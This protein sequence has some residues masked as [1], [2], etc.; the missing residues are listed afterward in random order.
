MSSSSSFSLV[1]FL[2]HLHPLTS[3]ENCSLI[4]ANFAQRPL[5][6]VPATLTSLH[7]WTSARCRETLQ[8]P[9]NLEKVLQ[10]SGDTGRLRDT[11]VMHRRSRQP[12]SLGSLS[13]RTRAR[14]PI[15]HASAADQSLSLLPPADETCQK[16]Q[17]RPKKLARP[18]A[19]KK[20]SASGKK[21]FGSQNASSDDSESENW[22]A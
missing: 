6:H 13:L 12:E 21:K 22:A 14:T 19:T 7:F 16:F 20:T 10:P 1:F 11:D 2:F 4:Y 8:T 15:T 17:L 3:G 18:R 5:F 9:S